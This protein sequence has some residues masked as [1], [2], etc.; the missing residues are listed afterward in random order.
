MRKQSGFDAAEH[1][2]TKR[3]ALP[4]GLALMEKQKEHSDA[5]LSA[6]SGK[7]KTKVGISNASRQLLWMGR[8]SRPRHGICCKTGSLWRQMR[9]IKSEHGR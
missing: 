6:Q 9:K 7:I 2:R 4:P 3:E 1:R 8:I 5:G